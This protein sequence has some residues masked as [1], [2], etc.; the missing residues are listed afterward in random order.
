MNDSG[1]SAFCDW[2][3]ATRVSV[4]FQSNA[5]FV[6]SVQ[7]VHIL[8]VATFLIAVFVIGSKLIRLQTEPQALA[9]LV[10]GSMPRIW[11]ALAVLLFTGTLLTITEPARE[12]LNWAFRVKMILV[13]VLGML[14]Y[15]LQS[16]ARGF[17][18]GAS[19][20]L[21]GR[22]YARLMGVVLFLI[23]TAVVTAGRWIAYVG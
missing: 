15:L 1:L 19:V 16:R 9:A 20:V 5:W 18:R 10:R 17:R 11:I 21:Y 4:A 2:L 7:T 22:V 3:S 13:V 8:S 12:L 14:L 23:G 6:P